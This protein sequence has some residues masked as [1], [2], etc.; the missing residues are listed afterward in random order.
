MAGLSLPRLH[1]FVMLA[2]VAAVA[3]V[4]RPAQARGPDGI[5]DVAERVIDAVVKRFNKLNLLVNNAGA[6]KRGDFLKLSDADWADGYAL[7]FFGAINSFSGIPPSTRS[8]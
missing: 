1:F 5:A 7:K 4:A 3:L 6:T 8:R 2:A